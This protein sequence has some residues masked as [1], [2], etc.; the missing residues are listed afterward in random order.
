[1]S[2]RPVPAA[3]PSASLPRVEDSGV[4]RAKPAAKPAFAPAPAKQQPKPRTTSAKIARGFFAFALIVFVL[5]FASVLLGA[6]GYL[7]IADDIPDPSRLAAAQS[8]FASTKIFDSRGNLIVEL[9]DPTDP[10]AGR[11]THIPLSQISPY[12][13][14][15]TIATE[16]PNFYRYNN[17]VGFDP[18]AIAR[19]LYYAITEREVVSGGSTITQQVARN[20]LLTPEER[21]SRTIQRKIR[22]IVLANELTRQYSRDQ[23]LEIYL[24]DNYYGNQAYGIEAAAQTYFNKPAKDLNLA[25]ASL[26]A[27]IPQS[28]VLWDPVTNKEGVL[29]RQ[30]DVL[31]LMVKAGY[32]KP[33]QIFEAQREIE[34]KA[35]SVS[36]PNVSS[37]APHFMQFVKQQLD[38]EYGAKGLYRDGLRVYTSLDQNTQRI[39]ENAIKGQIEKLRAKNVTN[40]AA[41]VIDPKSGEIR[42][43][44]GSADFNDATIDGQVNVAIMSRQ[45]GSA[46]KPFN[47]LAALEKGMT[48]AT[49]YWDKPVTFTNEYGQVY[50]PKNYDDKFHGPML[51]RE[52]LA[53]SMNIPAV[54]TLNFVTVPSFLEMAQRVGLNFP[55]ND[56][57]GLAITLGGA[58]A[59]LLDLT[60][61]YA[62]LADTGVRVLPTAITRV[63][64]ADGRLLRDYRQTQGQQVV[65][66][67][68]AY[69]ITSILSDN[70][71]R[72]RSFGANS[73]LKLSRPAAVKTGTTDDFRDNLTV[74]YTPDLV[75]GVWVGN[76]DNSPMQGVTGVTGAAPIWNQ[77]MEEA[78]A[79]VPASDFPPPQGV[80]GVEICEDG[81][82]VPSPNCPR[83]RIEFFSADQLPLPADENVERAVQAGNPDLA[84]QPQPQAANPQSPDILITQP[85]LDAPTP[86]GLLSIRGTVNPPGFQQY[87]VEYGDGENPAEWKWISGPHLSPVVDDQL[88]QW[89][90]EGLPA[91]RYTIRVTVNT[92]NGT[93]VGYT[94]F[95]VSP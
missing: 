69:L 34:A 48:P 80:V 19:A 4:A 73:P 23:I 86:R 50:T 61:A 2:L 46:I 68:H 93:R 53:R 60:S 22:E 71:A 17:G 83:K 74:G 62:V 56:Q 6:A 20:L 59:R 16:D 63:E 24:N 36:L 21:S 75:V 31:R 33:E 30:N 66:P 58:E 35:F 52:A 51:M 32:V 78:L 5:S 12:L 54:E 42:A 95:D 44:V 77:I 82:R 76:S 15:A 49:L 81:G 28:P 90:M 91:G 94:R 89:G 70:A 87:I 88:T 64:Y 41:V 92:S 55:P 3:A 7:L 57:Y 85:T 10:T 27:G 40:G 9:T 45:P 26:L 25:E 8:N 39:A 65:R 1:M 14:Q 18:I 47:Y 43:M 29:R 72:A 37:V 13:I 38:A 84:I 11:R 67:E 79:S